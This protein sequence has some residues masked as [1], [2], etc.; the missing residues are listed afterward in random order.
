[1]GGAYNY[2]DGPTECSGFLTGTLPASDYS[3]RP[4]DP[5]Q[6]VTLHGQWVL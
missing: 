6:D 1:M 5:A 2:W 3:L 4:L